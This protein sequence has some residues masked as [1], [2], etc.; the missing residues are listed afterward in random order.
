MSTDKDHW[1]DSK[2]PDNLPTF[3]VP[4]LSETLAS[5]IS[6]AVTSM[7]QEPSPSSDLTAN[8]VHLE[9][10]LSSVCKR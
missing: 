9:N 3:S 5:P 10:Y 8:M 1:Q 2:E 7:R 6:H 4:S